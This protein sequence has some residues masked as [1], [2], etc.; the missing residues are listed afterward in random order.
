MGI[1]QEIRGHFQQYGWCLDGDADVEDGGGRRPR[2]AIMK[3]DRQ[4]RQRK[5]ERFA[6]PEAIQTV[7]VA[8]GV[9]RRS[10]YGRTVRPVKRPDL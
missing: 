1:V 8:V 7:D 4:R 5:V 2:K 6:P 10:M 9:H 3:E